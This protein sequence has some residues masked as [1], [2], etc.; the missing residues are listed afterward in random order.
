MNKQTHSPCIAFD[1][2]RLIAIGTPADVSARVKAVVDQGPHGPVLVFNADTS[3]TVEWDLRGS[4]ADVVARVTA[5]QLSLPQPDETA[6]NDTAS[7]DNG[8]ASAEN[9]TAGAAN[10]RASASTPVPRAGPGRPKLG[11]V[12]REITL[13]PRHWEWLSAR[14]GGASV[15]LRKLVDQARAVSAP[16]DRVRAAQD[17]AYRFMS[18]MAG[19]QPGFEEATRALFAN[20]GGRFDEQI[21]SWPADIAQHA[22]TLGCSFKRVG[23]VY[24]GEVN[25][26][27]DFCQCL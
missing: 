26:T 1:G 4:L 2:Y 16:G 6:E 8:T 15:T 21:A 12:A 20:N 23:A 27:K 24:S 14:P 9:R 22:R 25:S 7:A 10:E 17:S 11:V 5:A 13:L 3:H 18:A 19:N